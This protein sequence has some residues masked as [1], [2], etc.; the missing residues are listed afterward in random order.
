MHPVFQRWR[1]H[2]TQGVRLIGFGSSNT[3]ASWHNHGRWCWF[4]WVAAAVR[5][6]VGR[7]VAT[8][9]CGI[10]GDSSTALLERCDRDV[11]P[12]QPGLVLVTIGG[13]DQRLLSPDQFTANLATLTA[14]LRSLGADVVFQT[15]YAPTV[16]G[17]ELDRFVTFMRLVVT[18]AAQVKAPV[19]D[20]LPRFLAW[21][22]ADL[23]A[24]QR[25]MLDPMHLNP[26]G[27]A[28]FGTYCC[29]GLGLADPP[30]PPDGADIAAGLLTLNGVSVR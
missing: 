3:E 4:D 8:I 18:A 5:D 25:I 10:S 29:R 9:N 2:P 11:T 16:E 28:L 27:H 6:Q 7:H 21:R 30:L 20:S 13:N 23:L 26:L 22:Q 14:R 19:I 12:L 17:A 1:E 24:Y 15:Y